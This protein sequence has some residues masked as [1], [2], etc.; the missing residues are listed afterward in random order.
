[1]NE[2]TFRMDDDGKRLWAGERTYPAHLY[3]HSMTDDI[4]PDSQFMLNHPTYRMETR[5]AV[6]WFENG[7]QLSTIWGDAT[8]STNSITLREQPPFVE[9]PVAVEVG[10]LAPF[11]FTREAVEFEVP[12]G[13]RV[14]MPEYQSSLWGEPLPYV[15]VPE[16]HRVADLV[17][18]LPRDI[19]LPEGEWNDAQGFCDLLI[20]AGLE[21]TP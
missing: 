16:F 3:R 19:D 7:W 18:Y 4:P 13:G 9:E 6:V 12:S 1:M 14:E 2:Y 5:R 17:M 21:R 20:T 11:L 8:Y 10:V 15:T